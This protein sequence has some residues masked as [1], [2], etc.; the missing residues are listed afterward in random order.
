MKTLQHYF[1]ENY[2]NGI[3]DHTIRSSVDGEGNVSY[4]IHPSNKDGDTLDF[5]VFN[6]TN[7]PLQQKHNNGTTVIKSINEAK[8]DYHY[9]EKSCP[10]CDKE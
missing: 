8:D 2:K 10:I 7:V 5:A 3:V 9:G 1:L 4:Y 6:N